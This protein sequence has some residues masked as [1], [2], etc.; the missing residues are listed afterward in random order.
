MSDQN[1]KATLLLTCPDRKGL[2]SRIS[3]FIF[4][5]GGNIV[6]LDEHV[7]FQEQRF[8]LRVVWDMKDFSV[9][10]AQ[11]NEVFFSMAK[12]FNAKWSVRLNA[13]KPRLAVFV[14]KYDHCLQEMLWRQGLGDFN[15]DIRLII[16]NHKDLQF[17][18]QR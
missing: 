18:A 14:S 6:E 8:F 7:E 4:E 2:V 3:H 13:N 12:E 5:R 17:L 15:C 11:L 16:S 10:P 9:I 1:L